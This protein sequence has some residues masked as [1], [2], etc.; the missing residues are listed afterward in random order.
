MEDIERGT[1]ALT[2]TGRELLA[3]NDTRPQR[4]FCAAPMVCRVAPSILIYFGKKK[5]PEMM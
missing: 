1:G 4:I 5:S 2:P 3:M